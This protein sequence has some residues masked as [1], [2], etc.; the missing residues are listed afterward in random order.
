MRLEAGAFVGLKRVI[1]KSILCRDVEVGLHVGFLHIGIRRAGAAVDGI[2]AVLMA[3]TI[4]GAIIEICDPAPDGLA[5]R[6]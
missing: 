4:L 3:E 2:V 5:G 1:R 6:W